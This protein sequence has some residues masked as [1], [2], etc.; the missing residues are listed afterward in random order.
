[1]RDGISQSGALFSY[2]D[3]EKRVVSRT[4]WIYGFAYCTTSTMWMSSPILLFC[5]FFFNVHFLWSC[6]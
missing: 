6:S 5:L 3:L 4:I 1:M 2:L